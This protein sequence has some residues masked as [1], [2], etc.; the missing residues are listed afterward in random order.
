[1]RKGEVQLQE[2]ILVTFFVIVIIALGLVVFYR[3]SLNSI[4]NYEQEYR[5]QQLLSSLITLPNGFIYTNLGSSQNAID[6]SK[7]F[8]NNLNYGFKT[9]IIMQVYPA[10]SNEIKCDLSNYPN[11]NTFIVYNKTSYKLKNTLVESMPISL[12]YP[13]DDNYKV[14]KL[15]IYLYY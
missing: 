11:C 4:N 12:Y 15:I 13:L 2:S 6:T 1:M 8:Y 9:M 7:L 14:G 10:I 3:F 5:E